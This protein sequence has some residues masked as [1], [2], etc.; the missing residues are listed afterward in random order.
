MRCTTLAQYLLT[1]LRDAGIASDSGV[2]AWSVTKY[3]FGVTEYVTTRDGA[4]V[5]RYNKH[6]LTRQRTDQQQLVRRRM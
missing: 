4:C 2:D 6:F 3:T 1:E 5:I